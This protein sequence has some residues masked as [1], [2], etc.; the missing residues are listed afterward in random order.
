MTFRKMVVA[1]AGIAVLAGCGADNGNA[2]DDERNQIAAVPPGDQ[3]VSAE[4]E[5]AGEHRSQDHG[6]YRTLLHERP[7]EEAA[8]D[9]LLADGGDEDRQER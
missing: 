8:E 7:P 5:Q 6:K 9:G 2:Q 3:G 4:N 1:L